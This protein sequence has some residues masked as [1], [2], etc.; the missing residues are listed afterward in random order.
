[1]Y[2]KQGPDMHFGLSK[3]NLNLS[4]PLIS[5]KSEKFPTELRVEKKK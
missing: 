2:H 1:M 4:Q 5:K 3:W